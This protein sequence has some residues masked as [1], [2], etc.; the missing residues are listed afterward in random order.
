MRLNLHCLLL[1]T[2]MVGIHWSALGQ[3][4]VIA[5]VTKLDNIQREALLK[6]DTVTM[7]R[8]F[9]KDFVVNTPDNKVINYRQVANLIR[10]GMLDY[11][12]FERT[13]DKVTISGN[14]AVLMGQEVLRPKNKAM[15]AGK[16]VTRRFTNV[17]VQ[18]GGSWH[19]L[20]RQASNTL[21]Q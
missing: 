14:V 3:A 1:L 20:A 8:L 2:F 7:Q 6:G 9:A 19:L 21:V 17:W 12:S 5:E 11:A 4:A 13:I 10:N 18:T 15:N 16:T